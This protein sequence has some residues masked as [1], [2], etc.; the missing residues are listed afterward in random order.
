[1]CIS[2]YARRKLL[3]IKE[4][5]ILTFCG[6]IGNCGKENIDI[7]IKYRLN[8]ELCLLESK[9]LNNH[10]LRLSHIKE[11]LSDGSSKLFLSRENSNSVVFL[12]DPW[13]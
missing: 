1:M 11:N 9:P 12:Y 6:A 8:E 2:V 7:A 3:V 5:L 13:F 4:Y 10:K